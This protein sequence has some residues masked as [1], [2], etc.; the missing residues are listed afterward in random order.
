MYNSTYRTTLTEY[1]DV[2]DLVSEYAA[3]S[4]V[5]VMGRW[6]YF[7]WF[8][9]V[10]KLRK[11]LFRFLSLGD[12]SSAPPRVPYLRVRYLGFLP[13]F[14]LS[15]WATFVTQ[16]E[17]I[18]FANL[19]VL[20]YSLFCVFVVYYLARL[21][22]ELLDHGRHMLL[23]AIVGFL[24]LLPFVR[25]AFVSHLF[26]YVVFLYVRFECLFMFSFAPSRLS[27]R[28]QRLCFSHISR[29]GE[30]SPSLWVGN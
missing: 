13:V 26:F 28:P 6:R 4:Y 3:V 16:L 12:D 10:G 21:L 29:W 17:S 19:V 8:A 14:I 22:A 23:I 20:I 11:K 25:Y 24:R 27:I 30:Y 7:T 9:K 1:F 15:P 5:W 18:E 2:V